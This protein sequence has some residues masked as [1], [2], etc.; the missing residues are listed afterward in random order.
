MANNSMN[1]KTQTCR[2]FVF[3]NMGHLDQLPKSGGQ[4]SARRV[5]KGFEEEGM[6]IVPI[7]R[8]RAELSTKAGHV[9]E[10]GFFAVYDL[11]KMV[12][13]M[14]FGRRR[15]AAFV[16]MTYAGALVP[17]ELILT[18]TAKLLGY[19]CIEYLQGG[20][21]MDT[22]PKGGRLHKWMFKK[23]M[24]MQSLVLF[25]G[26]DA[27][28]LTQAVTNTK[29]HYFPSYIRDEIIPQSVPA[30]PDGEI[31]LC[32]FG[33]T[34][35]VKNPVVTVEA[36]N[37]LCK[38]HPGKRITLA[39]VGSDV[40]NKDY[41]KVLAEHIERSPYK[42]MITRKEN[43]PFGYLLEMMQ[44]QHFYIFPT[45]EK[46]EGHSNALN[47]AMSQGLVPIACDYHFNKTVIGDE[48]IVVEGYNPSDYAD[49]I[50]WIL[51]NCDLAG[52]SEQMWR[53]VK[54]NFSYSIVNRTTCN[55]IKTTIEEW[56]H[57]Q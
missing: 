57:C 14:L 45:K 51:E 23:N 48:N 29:L 43:S 38:R 40:V 24:D 3:A 35:P 34:S 39:I 22:Y 52:L 16:Q 9:A 17:Y 26:M 44:K 10:V 30:K 21:V 6:E 36:F 50:D 31:N 27:L 53:R 49:K 41:Q 13:K 46:A 25:E 42:D 15:N 33:R 12:A 4:S 2:L 37:I 28:T 32:Y 11:L 5:M 54:E 56:K 20:L 7:R 19:K 55:K 47:E 8:H 1:K 18:I